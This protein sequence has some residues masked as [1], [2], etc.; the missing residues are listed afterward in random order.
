MKLDHRGRGGGVVV[1]QGLGMATGRAGEE[2]REGDKIAGG[3]RFKDPRGLG[4]GRIIH[5][6]NE[7]AIC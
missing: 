6:S 5:A 7:V 3:G 2:G 4:I 1:R